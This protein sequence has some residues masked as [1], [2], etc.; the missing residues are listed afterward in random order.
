[1]SHRGAVPDCP[2]PRCAGC[3][4]LNSLSAEKRNIR[5]TERCT[6]HCKVCVKQV[7]DHGLE[8]TASWREKELFTLQQKSSIILF[9]LPHSTHIT[10]ACT[11]VPYDPSLFSW[12]I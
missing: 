7:T 6:W 12:K 8:E 11:S 9:I 1:M 4:K 10:S 3:S 2:V 5:L